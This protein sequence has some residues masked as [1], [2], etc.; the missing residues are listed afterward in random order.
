MC[1]YVCARKQVFCHV[2]CVLVFQRTQPFVRKTHGAGVE[3][4]MNGVKM[5]V[6]F[7]FCGGKN[8]H[9]CCGK[10]VFLFCVH[11]KEI[12]FGSTMNITKVWKVAH[13]EGKNLLEKC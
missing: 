9:M 11:F 2:F 5:C 6:V 8:K 4:K 10:R 3:E 1:W 12:E 7:A 13:F